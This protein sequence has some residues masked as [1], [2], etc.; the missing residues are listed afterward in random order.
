MT[1]ALL[2]PFGWENSC[3]RHVAAFGREVS[4]ELAASCQH[5]PGLTP[6][7]SAGRMFGRGSNLRSVQGDLE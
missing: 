4:R 3:A 6:A 5:S 2:I 1:A 7:S